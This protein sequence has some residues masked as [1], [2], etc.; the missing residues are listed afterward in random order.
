[1]IA[2]RRI[3]LAAAVLFGFTCRYA[4]AQQSPGSGQQAP[5]SPRAVPG[6]KTAEPQSDNDDDVEHVTDVATGV[7]EAS[8]GLGESVEVVDNGGVNVAA[9]NGELMALPADA[10]FREVVVMAGAGRVRVERGS[11]AARGHAIAA[12]EDRVETGGGAASGVTET[13][14]V[15]SNVLGNSVFGPQGVTAMLRIA[16]DITTTATAGCSLDRYVL[17][18]TGNRLFDSIERD[19]KSVV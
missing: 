5:A 14:M 16:D 17:R 2:S 11:T 1:M 19:R 15:Y 8:S 6:P 4:L 10:V 3:R 7:I 13:R 9:E 12:G 18:F